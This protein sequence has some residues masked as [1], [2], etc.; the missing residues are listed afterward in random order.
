MLSVRPLAV[1]APLE[2]VVVFE[3]NGN[4]S[5]AHQI[6]QAQSSIAQMR[7]GSWRGNT[8]GYTD[9]A[10]IS[11]FTIMTL[12]SSGPAYDGYVFP[13]KTAT[14]RVKP[15]EDPN[16]VLKELK[17]QPDV[18]G[19]Y[20]N[21]M[22]YPFQQD[23]RYCGT[24]ANAHVYRSDLR[25]SWP[26]CQD[27]DKFVWYGNVCG[28]NNAIQWRGVYAIDQFTKSPRIDCHITSVTPGYNLGS[29]GG[30]F[31]FG[32]CGTPPQATHPGVLPTHVC[33]PSSPSPPPTQSGKE[34]RIPRESVK[35]G[36]RDDLHGM[37]RIEA[38]YNQSV[39]AS[40]E[41][42]NITVAVLDT[43]GSRTLDLNTVSGLSFVDDRMDWTDRQKHGTHVAG[44]IGGINNGDGI[45]GVLPGVKILPLKVLSDV[46]SGTMSDVMQALEY[47]AKNGKKEGIC[48]LNL[49]LGGVGSASDPICASIEAVAKRGMVVVVAAGNDNRNFM[50]VSPAACPYAITVTAVSSINN[51]PAPFS[52]WIPTSSSFNDKYRTVSAPGVDILSSVPGGGSE[53]FSG[54]SMATPHVVGVAARCFAHG[55]CQVRDSIGTT[56]TKR[57][58][59][60]IWN[61]HERDIKYRWHGGNDPVV[62][63]KYYGPLVWA[64]AWR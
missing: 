53:A 26:R 41:Y 24:T 15:G 59:E 60:S 38:I 18:R 36:E 17:S 1:A 43:G 52:N 8:Q 4:M 32:R 56:N 35:I 11:P 55:A 29:K 58:L 10:I 28:E 64:G 16:K 48:V 45:V 19:I 44:I 25:V 6:Y 12:T 2:Y 49:S 9:A 21:R 54:T 61:K 47:V 7:H 31:L 39:P 42:Q 30:D 50:E 23:R 3:D 51:T 63:N 20:P 37:H 5:S 13:V 22:Y 62:G 46:G 33:N 14:I 57:V 34:Q 40:S 27:E